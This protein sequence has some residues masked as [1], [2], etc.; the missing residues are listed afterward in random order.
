MQKYESFL[1]ICCVMMREKACHVGRIG[2]ELG[3]KLS[4]ELDES[5]SDVDLAELTGLE[6]TWSFWLKLLMKASWWARMIPIKS[7]LTF[8]LFSIQS[9]IDIINKL[10]PQPIPL[11]KNLFWDFVTQT[12]FWPWYV[13]LCSARINSFRLTSMH[14]TAFGLLLVWER[15]NVSEKRQPPPNKKKSFLLVGLF[16]VLSASRSFRD[17]SSSR[18][19]DGLEMKNFHSIRFNLFFC[20]FEMS[21]LRTRNDN[22]FV[23]TNNERNSDKEFECLTFEIQMKLFWKARRPSREGEQRQPTF[24]SLVVF[25]VFGKVKFFI[26]LLVYIKQ[27]FHILRGKVLIKTTRQ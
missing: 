4:F 12:F 2:C 10:T 25:D 18:L 13:R 27:A 3:W 21:K 26:C 19:D 6:L 22:R 20:Y 7:D 15:Q 5:V 11:K 16:V 23:I 8:E 17:S 24:V 9:C 1:L 14:K